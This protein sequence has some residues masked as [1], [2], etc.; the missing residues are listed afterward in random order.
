MMTNSELTEKFEDIC[1]IHN[2]NVQY[3]ES[4]ENHANKQERTVWVRKIADTGDF[5]AALHEV[6]HVMCDP[7]SKPQ[8]HLEQLDI[9]TKA[10]QWALN[11]HGNNVDGAWWKRLHESLRQYYVAVMDC[12][13]PAYALLVE[14]EGHVTNIRSKVSS[15]GAPSPIS[16]S[17]KS[18]KPQT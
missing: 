6:G 4:G 18:S 12:T 16:F 8:N 3:V 14:A 10:W 11:C 5:A 15:F 9:E 1:R 13:H 17:K 7:D 2:I